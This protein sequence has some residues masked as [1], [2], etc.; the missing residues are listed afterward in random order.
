[1]EPSGESQQREETPGSG[2]AAGLTAPPRPPAAA[3]QPPTEE[4]PAQPAPAAGAPGPL[5]PESAAGD[6]HRPQPEDP[7][8]PPSGEAVPGP[9]QAPHAPGGHPAQ[10]PRRDLQLPLPDASEARPA[11]A[12]EHRE[13][14]APP[15]P[16]PAGSDRGSPASEPGANA[17]TAGLGAG[18]PEGQAPEGRGDQDDQDLQQVS[19]EAQDYLNSL[20]A[21]CL[22][23][24]EDSPSGEED[25]PD[26][27]LD[28]S[29]DEAS[30]S[31]QDEPPSPAD[32]SL[33]LD[34][35]ARRIEI[36]EVSAGSGVEAANSEDVPCFHRVFVLPE[37]LAP[38]APL[39]CSCVSGAELRWW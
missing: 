18:L 27:L 10:A 29:P 1:M 13:L 39:L 7:A 24:A 26:L 20:L 9:E 16:V 6:G 33:S 5:A 11:D 19:R 12:P 38:G 23:G 15:Q 30:Y 32:G 22:R 25:D 14:Q 34:D 35:L 36:A 28:L 2:H 37:E 21:G 3:G 8:A 31:L 4:R 17:Q